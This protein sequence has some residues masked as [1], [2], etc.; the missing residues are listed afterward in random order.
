MFSFFGP[1]SYSIAS[2]DYQRREAGGSK[3]QRQAGSK[4]D[5]IPIS[6]PASSVWA[7]PPWSS[8]Q[9]CSPKNTYNWRHRF[10]GGCSK[11]SLFVTAGTIAHYQHVKDRG[12]PVRLWR[13]VSAESQESHNCEDL[14]TFPGL[15]R[16]NGPNSPTFLQLARSRSVASSSTSASPRR[17]PAYCSQES[18][19]SLAAIEVALAP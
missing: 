14:R 3:S 19:A 8:R 10:W 7:V 1:R 18:H 15:P 5:S 13:C 17:T 11:D 9:L 6:T 12:T 16:V 2:R 4:S